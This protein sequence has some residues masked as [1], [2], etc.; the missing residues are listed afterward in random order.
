MQ[1]WSHTK[2]GMS[3]FLQNS[4]KSSIIPNIK[5]NSATTQIHDISTQVTDSLK[6]GYI[7]LASSTQVF[8]RNGLKELNDVYNLTL[9]NFINKSD[10]KDGNDDVAKV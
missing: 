6:A 3:N 1:E 2:K 8:E 10:E 5:L 4:L 9:N 7:I